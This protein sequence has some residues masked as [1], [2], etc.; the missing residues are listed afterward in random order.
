ME[1]HACKSDFRAQ[2]RA[3]IWRPDD[4]LTPP[5]SK[6][7]AEIILSA[8][9]NAATR[10]T[11][12]SLAFLMALG[13]IGMWAILGPSSAY[14]D[15]WQLFI[16]T[17]TSLITFLMVFL[18]QRTQNKDSPG[19]PPQAQRADRRREWGEQSP[20]QR[21]AHG[22]AR[23]ADAPRRVPEAAPKPPKNRRLPRSTPSKKQPSCRLPSPDER[24]A[25]PCG[26]KK[27]LL[28]TEDAPPTG[29]PCILP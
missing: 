1:C 18:I 19:D 10:W 17:G 9:A 20:D 27:M 24:P 2:R 28:N 15:T 11:G 7:V 29:N 3:E 6:P 13:T 4:P 21:R 22:R 16:N 25:R 14:S 23:P 5:P 26:T 8:L 12:S